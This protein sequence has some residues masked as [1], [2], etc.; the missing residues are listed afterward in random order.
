MTSCWR[1]ISTDGGRSWTEA[2]LGAPFDL[3]AAAVTD[4]GGYFIGDYHGLAAAGDRFL[5][6]FATSTGIVAA[7]RPSGTDTS[8]N[9][10]TEVNRYALRR[11]IMKK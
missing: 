2:P 5:A 8:S 11:R 7:T 10:R 4:G 1:L 6:F 3:T 9:G